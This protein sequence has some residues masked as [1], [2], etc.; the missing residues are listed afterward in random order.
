MSLS[1]TVNLNVFSQIFGKVFSATLGFATTIILR[2]LF[3]AGTFGDY[4]FIL[5]LV[6]LF[7]SL[8]DFGTHL[9]S[10]NLAAQDRTKEAKVLGNAI[11]L[12]LGL[13]LATFL[14]FGLVILV[15][16]SRQA[17]FLNLVLT[18]PLIFLINFKDSLLV[19]F[20]IKM[21]LYFSSLQDFLVAL[22]LF[23]AAVFTLL[24]KPELAF[25]IILINCCYLIVA[26][27]FFWLAHKKITISWQLDFKII[28]KLFY[29]SAPLGII[30]VSYTLYSKVDTLILK[31]VWGSASVGVY[32][33]SYKIYENLVLPAAFLMNAVLP[34]IAEQFKLVKLDKLFFLLQRMFDL[35]ILGALALIILFYCLAPTLVK[36]FTGGQGDEVLLFRI[37]LLAL[38]FAYLNH[39][40]GYT[41]IVLSQQKKSLVIA[42]VALVFN[43]GANLLLIPL[44]AGRGAAVITVLTQVLVFVLSL[45][46]LNFK[47]KFRPRLYCW[48][49]TLYDFIKLRGGIFDQSI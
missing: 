29:Q 12:R 30:L 32:G 34:I 14:I 20:H 17:I 37:L 16:F 41:N 13:A 39:L 9:V 11:L 43:F 28:K 46:V 4:I 31:F 27:P 3:G 44:F 10:V 33:L 5:S 26:V 15:F 6:T 45:R 40:T 21:R 22:L 38:P 7:V 42:L 36:I 25:Y 2:R 35:L 23:L 8:A 47:L 18:L 24:V 19:L 1:R 49:K 48:P